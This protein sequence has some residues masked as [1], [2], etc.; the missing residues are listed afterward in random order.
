MKKKQLETDI[1]ELDLGLEFDLVYD[2][3]TPSGLEKHLKAKGD[4]DMNIKQGAVLPL[5]LENSQIA[6]S[7]QYWDFD[8]DAELDLDYTEKPVDEEEVNFIVK[9]KAEADGYLSRASLDQGAPFDLEFG[10][11]TELDYERKQG[12]IQESIS[13]LEEEEV[14]I[15]GTSKSELLNELWSELDAGNSAESVKEIWDDV[16]ENRYLKDRNIIVPNLNPAAE[17][18]ALAAACAIGRDDGTCDRFVEIDPESLGIRLSE[19]AAKEGFQF[20]LLQLKTEVENGCYPGSDTWPSC[21]KII[22]TFRGSDEMADWKI[23]L[24]QGL[25][26]PVSQHD[27]A[28]DIVKQMQEKDIDIAYITGHSLGGGLATAAALNSGEQAITFNA[29]SVVSNA[30]QNLEADAMAR[31][32][33]NITH[34]TSVNDPLY[35][36]LS[37]LG[38]TN[39]YGEQV[40][41]REQNSFSFFE[42]SHGMEYLLPISEQEQTESPVYSE[43]LDKILDESMREAK[44]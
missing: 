6:E 31:A 29:A 26:R 22:V 40:M 11:K 32:Q 44:R 21:Q 15:L 18:A 33:E 37:I 25:G 12:L 20:K 8:L 30:Y 14:S 16:I 13:K 27:S 3:I 5:L 17:E 28:L 35:R 4:V 10:L 2:R 39:R 1:P 7:S 34:Y 36:A 42:G 38:L 41:V 24:M 23:N 9:A 43:E 19:K